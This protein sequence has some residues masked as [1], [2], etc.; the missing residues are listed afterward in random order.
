MLLTKNLLHEPA[1]LLEIYEAVRQGKTMVPICLVGRGYDYKEA[2]DHLSDLKTGLGEPGLT[3]LRQ[4]LEARSSAP[5]DKTL[6]VADLQ[7][8]LLATLPRIIAVN[9]EPESGRNQLDATVANVIARTKPQTGAPVLRRSSARVTPAAVARVQGTTDEP[10]FDQKSEPSFGNKSERYADR[11]P[12]STSVG[13][14]VAEDD[15]GG[16]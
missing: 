14:V 1:V 12:G 11:V 9:W 13:F 3:E 16:A 5:D 7:A 6:G 4:A 8:A 10:S 15:D 2:I